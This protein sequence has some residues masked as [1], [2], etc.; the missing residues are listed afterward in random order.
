M[1]NG[2]INCRTNILKVKFLVQIGNVLN[3]LHFQNVD[4]AL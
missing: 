3:D 1:E 4:G 2:K